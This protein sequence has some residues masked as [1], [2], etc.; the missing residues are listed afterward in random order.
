VVGNQPAHLP[1]TLR[2]IEYISIYNKGA[3]GLGFV[4]KIA[5]IRPFAAQEDQKYFQ[6][7]QAGGSKISAGGSRRIWSGGSSLLYSGK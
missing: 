6:E 7:D 2:Y 3:G 1:H 4:L 5:Y